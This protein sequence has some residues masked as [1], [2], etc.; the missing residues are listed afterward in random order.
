MALIKTPNEKE[1]AELY[2]GFSTLKVG[3]GTDPDMYASPSYAA[4]KVQELYIGSLSDV[5][6]GGFEHD[7]SPVILVLSHVS[8]YNCVLGINLRYTP[9]KI[10][11]AILRYVIESNRNRIRDNLPIMVD[12]HA[13]KRA[14]PAVQG[15]TRLYKLTLL[16][17]TETYP[18]LE[19]EE[20]AKQAGDQWSNHYKKFM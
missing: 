20:A 13:L 10:R 5:R 4:K 15:A 2:R 14:V 16:R 7:A 11:L 12:W 6:Y 1:S 8:I 19:W 9:Q 17:V 3:A 18:L